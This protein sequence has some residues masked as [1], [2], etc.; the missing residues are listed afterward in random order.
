MPEKTNLVAHANATIRA[1]VSKVWDALVNP[2]LIK[3]YM[4]GATVV[5]DWKQGSSIV[6]KGEWKGKPFEDRGVVLEIDPERRLVYDHYSPL[7]GPDVPDNHHKVSI[8]LAASDGYV[9]LFLSQD[10][11]HSDDARK[12][13]QRNWEAVVAGIKKVAEA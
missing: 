11:N 10:N 8:E 4:F 12:H 9:R 7:T 5:S 6:W 2:D 3:K 1:P 13:A